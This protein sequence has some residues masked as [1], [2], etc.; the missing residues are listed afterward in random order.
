MA[1]CNE[2]K[3]N[4]KIQEIEKD[5]EKLESKIKNYYGKI[6]PD[7]LIWNLFP[8]FFYYKLSYHNIISVSQKTNE[9]GNRINFAYYCIKRLNF[10]EI[11]PICEIF[12]SIL[13]AS[14]D[15]WSKSSYSIKHVATAINQNPLIKY[16]IVTNN[17]SNINLANKNITQIK[18]F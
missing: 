15:E 18:N 9:Q 16:D 5:E 10:N 14:G 1:E 7:Q 17:F 3:I 4:E 8:D 11:A 2:K 6:T 13:K 12:D